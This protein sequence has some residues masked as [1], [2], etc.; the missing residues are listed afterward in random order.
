MNLKLLINETPHY[1]HGSYTKQTTRHTYKLGARYIVTD[2][3][4]AFGD[5]VEYDEKEEIYRK[6][7]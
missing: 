6:K 3:L 7:A 4:I 5:T 1:C 2:S